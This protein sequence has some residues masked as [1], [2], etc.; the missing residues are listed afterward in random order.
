[1]ASFSSLNTAL[2]ALRYQQV[3]L[4]IASTNVANGGVDGY[5]RRRVVGETV[6]AGAVPALW[7]RSTEV[8][9]G[10]RASS[11][12]RMVDPYLEV[13]G[14]AE[15]A[16]QSYLDLQAEALARVETGLA[17]PGDHGLAAAISDFRK[18]L[19]D[20]VN[21]PGSDAA[22]SQVLEAAG[23]VADAIRL[24]ARNLADESGDQQARLQGTIAD[25]N[26]TA[27]QLAATNHS[28]AA[29]SLSESDTAS[30]LDE[31][32]RLAMKLAELTGATAE[33]QADGTMS[34]TLGTTPLVTGEDNGVLTATGSPIAFAV[35]G[36]AV[37]GTL[38]GEVGAMSDL[39]DHK[40]P[41]YLAGLADVA[42]TFADQ[43][44]AQH[45]AGYDRDGLAGGPLF[46]YDPADVAGSITV[47]IDDPAKLAASSVASDQVYDTGNADKLIDAITV[48]DAYRQLVNG[49]GTTVASVQRLAANQQALTSQV[50]SSREQLAGVSLD[51]ETVNMLSAQRAYE[52]AARVMTTVDSML[53]TLINR[54]GLVR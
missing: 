44:N 11:V 45:A 28:I 9:A 48:D 1:M 35:D 51:E 15:H 26:T 10:V 5:V 16:K 12:D 41:D 37:S 18:A 53:D 3:A 20:L 4:D 34:V 21:A 6:G 54:T 23:T 8:G 24:Q 50:D 32:D 30:L 40:L 7:S 39:L 33:V 36:A 13:R 38:G 14:R 2:S 49:F 43:L 31:R 17:E 29:A 46:T 47:A 22:R 52:A 42:K 27:A 25:V 19:H